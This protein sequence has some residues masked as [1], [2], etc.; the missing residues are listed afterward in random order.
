[1]PLN[2]YSDLQGHV[3]VKDIVRNWKNIERG[4][5]N[6]AIIELVIESTGFEY[7]PT[8]EEIS[9]PEN[10]KKYQDIVKNMIDSVSLW[11]KY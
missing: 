8:M 9:V 6:Q 3:P 10:R 4:E 7:Q 2:L 11:C 5:K 1:M